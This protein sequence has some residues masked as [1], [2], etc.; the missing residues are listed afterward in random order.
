MSP[1][2]PQARVVR[3]GG[4]VVAQPPVPLRERVAALEEN[5]GPRAR[6]FLGAVIGLWPITAVMLLALG[7]MMVAMLQG[8]S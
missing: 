4:I 6:S 3:K 5:L 8:S 2:L 7:L 1:Y